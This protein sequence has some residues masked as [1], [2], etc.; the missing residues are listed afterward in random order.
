MFGFIGPNS[1]GKTTAIRIIPRVLE[2]DAREVCWRGQHM[3][4]ELRHRVGH[5]ARDH[6]QTF[7]TQFARLEAQQQQTL[8]QFGQQTQTPT[9]LSTL[10]LR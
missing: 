5:I 4:D 7:S 3:N 8:C 1:A 9:N 6:G 2:P 10:S